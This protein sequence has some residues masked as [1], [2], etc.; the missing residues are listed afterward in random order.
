M[1]LEL[2]REG[3]EDGGC[4]Q[5]EH[6][7]ADRLPGVLWLLPLGCPH[8][9]PCAQCKGILFQNTP[10]DPPGIQLCVHAPGDTQRQQGVRTVPTK[11]LRNVPASP[12]AAD[13]RRNLRGGLPP[14]RSFP[15]S[16]M[17][18]HP[19][20]RSEAAALPPP[21]SFPCS[22]T[23]AG[24]MAGAPPGP[25][26]ADG[27]GSQ[28]R[29]P[30]A[31][32]DWARLPAECPGRA[33]SLP[34]SG[35]QSRA[36]APPCT[37]LGVQS[38]GEP[39]NA[40]PR[41]GPSASALTPEPCGIINRGHGRVTGSWWVKCEGGHRV[42]SRGPKEMSWPRAWGGFGRVRFSGIA[43]K[44]AMQGSPMQM[45]GLDPTSCEEILRMQLPTVLP[46]S[47]NTLVGAR[48]PSWMVWDS[49]L[50]EKGR[51]EAP[52]LRITPTCG[53]CLSPRVMVLSPHRA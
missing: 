49:L 16:G 6:L 22:L 13:P 4:H 34:R 19:P 43:L 39:R 46:A 3:G 45:S 5:R 52:K 51:R 12:T 37:S 15:P 40:V 25:P 21:Q 24:G 30:C 20:G 50:G 33:V 7:S 36:R 8:A 10:K 42:S 28:H 17:R 47:A 18:W 14:S 32:A 26:L 1:L 35:E 41:A 23:R 53:F 48:H 2:S 9:Q 11:G 27:V 29:W 44:S 38:R 31:T